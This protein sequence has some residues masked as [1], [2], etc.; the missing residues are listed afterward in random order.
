MAAGELRGIVPSRSP[1][2]AGYHIRTQNTNTVLLLIAEKLT[3]ESY[4]SLIADRL[5]SP[6]GLT[7]T[8]IPVTHTT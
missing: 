7:H 4:Q 8:S 1:V 2:R 5:T 3:G 6:L